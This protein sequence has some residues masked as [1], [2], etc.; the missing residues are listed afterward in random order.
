MNW[1]VFLIVFMF[2]FGGGV[3]DTNETRY[4]IA[5]DIESG[6]LIKTERAMKMIRL[7]DSF[8]EEASRA[9]GDGTNFRRFET[10]LFEAFVAK[11]WYERARLE[12]EMNKD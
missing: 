7:G 8:L 12:M 11:V 4:A 3:L 2:I 9:Y 6:K 10:D 1:L 5:S